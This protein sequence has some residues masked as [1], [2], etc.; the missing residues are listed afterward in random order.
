M[1][2]AV[3]VALLVG[4]ARPADGCLWDYDTLK[5]ET[6]GQPRHVPRDE[7]RRRRRARP[8]I[9]TGGAAAIVA[10]LPSVPHDGVYR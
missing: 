2:I 4:L 3:V 6:L 1:R 8:D 7:G 5:E 9:D 10:A